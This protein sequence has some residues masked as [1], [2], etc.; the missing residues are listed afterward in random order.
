M[1]PFVGNIHVQSI[2][3][4]QID[5]MSQQVQNLQQLMATMQTGNDKKS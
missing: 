5:I 4:T 2:P 1:N 3:L